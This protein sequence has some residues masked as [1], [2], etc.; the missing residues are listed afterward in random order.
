[1]TYRDT[2]TSL[3]LLIGKL[4]S[5][6]NVA[7]AADALQFASR[8]RLKNMRQ[9]LL[10]LLFS[11]SVALASPQVRYDGYKVYRV[12]V[13]DGEG[14]AD[15]ISSLAD[16]LKLDVWKLSRGTFTYVVRTEGGEGG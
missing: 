8:L 3:H 14:R 2:R 10:I 1:M 6:I 16:R 4:I 7:A 12:N 5:S 9:S 13:A 11:L 15:A